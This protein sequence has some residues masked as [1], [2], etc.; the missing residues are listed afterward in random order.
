MDTIN[1]QKYTTSSLNI[2]KQKW[3][4]LFICMEKAKNEKLHHTNVCERN[5]LFLPAEGAHELVNAT[6][7]H[8][9]KCGWSAIWPVTAVHICLFRLY[10][11]SIKQKHYNS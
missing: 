10:V 11:I 6:M 2:E 3:I 7:S 4:K 8:C 5:N 1:F 9:K